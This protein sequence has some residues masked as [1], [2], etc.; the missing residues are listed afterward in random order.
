MSGQRL[1]HARQ[2]FVEAVGAPRL[3][4][5]ASNYIVWWCSVS[6]E[7]DQVFMSREHRSVT[8]DVDVHHL[9]FLFHEP[10]ICRIRFGAR[11]ADEHFKPCVV[12]QIHER[13]QSGH[14]SPYFD[15]N[16]CSGGTAI[17]EPVVAR[18]GNVL[19]I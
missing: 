10:Q 14:M 15:V 6:W 16:Y 12:W 18:Y 19:I 11:G 13:C 4:I 1:M 2:S 9:V 5:R 7:L 3:V 17:A 8:V